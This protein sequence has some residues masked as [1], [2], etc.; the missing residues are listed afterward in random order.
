MG[1]AGAVNKEHVEIPRVLDF[2]LG[3]TKMGGGGEGEGVR[4]CNS[5][6]IVLEFLA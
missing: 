5:A 3:I 4:K 1:F 6:A 2:D